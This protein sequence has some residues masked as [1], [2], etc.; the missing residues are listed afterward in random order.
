MIGPSADNREQAALSRHPTSRPAS[1]LLRSSGSEVSQRVADVQLLTKALEMWRSGEMDS[2]HAALDELLHRLLPEAEMCRLCT[3]GGDM[4]ALLMEHVDYLT[5]RPG[6]RRNASLRQLLPLALTMLSVIAG[7]S[8]R[9]LSVPI[10]LTAR[11]AQILRLL[12]TGASNE[13]ISRKAHV[14]LNTVKYH[15]KNIYSK[16]GAGS[17]L[18]AIQRARRV[19]ITI[20]GNVDLSGVHQPS[21]DGPRHS[22]S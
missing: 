21:S 22:T 3:A 7:S 8:E 2:A 20:Q 15:L 9:A 10:S 11:E 12:A 17:R 6:Q 14:S 19:G 18:E 16:L 5:C 13:T 1:P 4:A